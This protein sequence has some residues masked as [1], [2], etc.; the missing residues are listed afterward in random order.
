[1]W[2]NQINHLKLF[3]SHFVQSESFN[4]SYLKWRKFLPVAS[5]P[6]WGSA[7][8][9]AHFWGAR[10][11]RSGGGGGEW[12][13]WP[14]LAQLGLVWWC[15]NKFGSRVAREQWTLQADVQTERQSST[16]MCRQT[17]RQWFQHPMCRQGGTGE[18][19]V[20][21]SQTPQ[22]LGGADRF[23]WQVC[24]QLSPGGLQELLPR[25]LLP[26][27]G[28]VPFVLAWAKPWAAPWN[29]QELAVPLWAWAGSPQ[30]P[31]LSQHCPVSPSLCLCGSVS[32]PEGSFGLP[33][34]WITSC[35]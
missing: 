27:L 4:S 26:C 28:R 35:N 20:D 23:V 3:V 30:T 31:S 13:L 25:A 24:I 10:N 33:G 29:P 15:C 12:S 19:L 32:S 17:G 2:K 5:W 34:I 14:L 16:Q 11:W 7:I 8:S 22:A 1:M 6:C 9:A 18:A 21:N